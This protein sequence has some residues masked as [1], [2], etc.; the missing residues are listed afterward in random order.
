MNIHQAG[1]T[2]IHKHACLFTG[3]VSF[4]RGKGRVEEGGRGGVE[5]GGGALCRLGGVSR[6][7]W[8]DC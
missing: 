1:D 3:C 4:A 8:A 7:D 2:L 6:L 5:G